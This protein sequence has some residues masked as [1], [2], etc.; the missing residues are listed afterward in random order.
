MSTFVAVTGQ[1]PEN[2]HI[3]R[4]FPDGLYLGTVRVKMHR[5]DG[6]WW[7]TEEQI[8][9][10]IFEQGLDNF[11]SPDVLVDKVF[12]EMDPEGGQPVELLDTGLRAVSPGGNIEYFTLTPELA[13][14]IIEINGELAFQPS[15]EVDYYL[16][17]NLVRTDQAC[18]EFYQSLKPLE[19]YQEDSSEHIPDRN[20]K[21]N[22]REAGDFYYNIPDDEEVF[23]VSA[24]V[25]E[26]P[27]AKA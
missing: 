14:Q 17:Y 26:K 19:L 15:Y 25:G 1:L 24:R 16:P 20:S 3:F 13:R 6:W 8:A 7:P 12:A 4:Q 2:T 9:R 21:K 22:L 27:E 10:A 23:I 11:V 5:E 18:A